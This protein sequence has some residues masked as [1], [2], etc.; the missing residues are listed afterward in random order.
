[1][2]FLNSIEKNSKKFNDPFLHWELDKPLT[3]EQIKE[4]ITAD[5]ANPSEH[6]L[7]YD[8]T[9][10]ID[11]GAPEFR[12]GLSHGGKALKFRCFITKENSNEFPNLMK[13]IKELRNKRTY[14]KV[15]V[16]FIFF[17]L[18][19]RIADFD[20]SCLFFFLSSSSE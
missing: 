2:S 6:N 19:P 20:N 5:I 1:M 4:I 18:T 15:K 3:E 11:G 13:L 17:L 16:T 12:K 14:E 8:G 10:A 9:R 7:N